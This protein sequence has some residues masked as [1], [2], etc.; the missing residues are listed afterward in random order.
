MFQTIS[1]TQPHRYVPIPNIWKV[2]DIF[3]SWPFVLDFINFFKC[4]NIT[5]LTKITYSTYNVNSGHKKWEIYVPKW[6]SGR[7]GKKA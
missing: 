7:R 5:L 4:N 1:L 2:G 6:E 3:M